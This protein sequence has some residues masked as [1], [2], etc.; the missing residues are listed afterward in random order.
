MFKLTRGNILESSADA[1]VNTVNIVGVMGK[2]IALQFKQSYP[3][4]FDAYRRACDAGEVQ[5]GR[6]FVFTTRLMHPPRYII[7]FPTKK[8]WRG[9]SELEHIEAGLKDLVRVLR[10]REIRS[11]A[12]PPLGCG[13][14]GLLWGDVLPR[15]K[16]ALAELP[17]VDVLVFEPAGAPKASELSVG[18]PRP[19]MTAARALYIL[20]MHQ[21]G[22]L[23]YRR[24]LLEIQKLAYF[25]Q[26]AGQNL[27]LRFVAGPYGPYADNL[28]HVLQI[29]EGHFTRGFDGTRSPEKEVELLDGAKDEAEAFLK[30]ADDAEARTHLERVARLIEGFETPYGLELL[31]TV[32]WVSTKDAPT[33]DISEITGR[34]RE[35]SDR[36]KRIFNAD[37][38]KVA[39]DRL[40]AE[41][42]VPTN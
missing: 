22:A 18:T 37:H 27:R 42:W 11:V 16:T 5:L 8:H 12:V 17:D 35:W 33:A 30:R 3:E 39:W 1:L 34:V 31:A 14:G 40:Q 23:D 28:N 4:N 10:E 19:K 32:H 9:K 13:Q 24:T 36:K 41:K 38:I 21:Y 2:G 6:M 25:L 7:N 15:I 29:F 20:L 26:E